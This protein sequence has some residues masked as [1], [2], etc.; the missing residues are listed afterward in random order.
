MSSR[1]SA[2]DVDLGELLARQAASHDVFELFRRRGHEAHHIGAVVRETT[3]H[4]VE[5]VHARGSGGDEAGVAVRIDA[6][7]LGDAVAVIGEI[8]TVDAHE[9]VGAVGG[10]HLEAKIF[11]LG[12]LLVVGEVVRRVIRGAERLHAGILD[13]LARTEIVRGDALVRAVPNALGILLAND[14]VDAEEAA[15]LQVAPLEDGVAGRLLDGLH[16]G[17][18]LLVIVAVARNE[19][20]GHTRRTHEAPLVVITGAVLADPDLGEVAELLVLPDLHGREV[21][22]VVDDGHVL[23]VV[24][25]ELLGP[26]GGEQEIVVQ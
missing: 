18:E 17:A 20:L 25:E 16:E 4:A 15:Q 12:E 9:A 14:V 5:V 24:V 26:F 23:R 11:D 7:N 8:R 21:A 3:A 13:D 1:Q 19:L 2:E 6:G 22:M 10:Q